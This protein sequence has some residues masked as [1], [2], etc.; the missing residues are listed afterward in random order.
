MLSFPRCTMCGRFTLRITLEE[1]SNRFPGPPDRTRN[2]PYE[3]RY[4]I[5]PSSNIL[6]VR[7]QND[8]ESTE[9]A[10]LQWGL[11]PHWSDDTSIGNN[12]IN[13]RSETVHEKPAF[14]QAFQRR[15]CLIPADGFYEWR[16]E[17]GKQPYLIQKHDQQLFAFAGIWEQW[18][19]DETG[20][21]LES[22]AIL[23]T[24]PNELM[25]PIHDR[26]PVILPQN[27]YRTWLNHDQHKVDH[28]QSILKPYPSRK[29]EAFPVRKMVNN[30]ENDRRQCTEPVDQ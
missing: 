19:D 24:Q 13:A 23:T 20:E 17:N 11:V 10:L 3:P 1:L 22:T 5:P 30:P 26:M 4:N 16:R 7:T 27:R 28:L 25:E 14:K 21:V 2:L 8:G 15:R 12:L 29:M 9:F 18:K 6:T